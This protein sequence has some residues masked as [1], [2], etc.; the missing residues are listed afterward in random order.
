MLVVIYNS[1]FR[2]L[3][4][5]KSVVIYDGKSFAFS[6]AVLYSVLLVIGTW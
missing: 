3:S 6:F 2:V 4:F 5:P 1:D